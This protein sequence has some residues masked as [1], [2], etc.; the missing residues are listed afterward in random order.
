MM[1]D[2]GYEVLTTPG[3]LEALK[4]LQDDNQQIDLLFSDVMMP[5]MSGVKLAEEA[6]KLRPGLKVLLTSGY[7]KESL[8]VEEALTELPLMAKPFRQATLAVQLRALFDAG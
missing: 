1:T 2:L 5:V 8:A 4:V 3:P 6:K 7:S